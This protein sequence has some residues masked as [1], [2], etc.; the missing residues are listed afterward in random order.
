MRLKPMMWPGLACSLLALLAPWPALADVTV[1]GRFTYVTGDT[2]TRSSFFSRRR[3]RVE[4][5]DNQEI[6][7]DSRTDLIT[8]IDNGRRLYWQG[9]RALADSIVE[10]LTAHHWALLAKEST[11]E[12]RAEWS[13]TLESLNDFIQVRKTPET[14]R[15]AGYTCTKWTVDAGPY[16]HLERWVARSLEVAHYE[17]ETERVVLASALDPL[18]RALLEMFWESRQ[19]PGLPLSG[20]MTVSTPSRQGRF[21]WEAVRVAVTP[22]PASAWEVPAGY[23]RVDLAAAL[24]ED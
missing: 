19:T 24:R 14:K 21:T 6:M 9:P 7:F 18:G 8:F 4:T 17:P 23:V 16:M 3:I 15:I 5:P 12:Q 13:R 2:A 1:V 20:S 22:I 10:G 11:A